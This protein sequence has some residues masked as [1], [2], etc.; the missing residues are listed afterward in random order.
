MR[1]GVD[2]PAECNP[3]FVCATE[4]RKNVR[5]CGSQDSSNVGR[6]TG[7]QY[8]FGPETGPPELVF[9]KEASEAPPQLFFSHEEKQGDYRVTIRFTNGERTRTAC[10][11]ARRGRRSGR[12]QRKILDIGCNERPEMYIDYMR[13]NYLRPEKLCCAAACQKAPTEGSDARV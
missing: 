1:V 5:I 6:W 11:P 12:R 10:T 4:R 13:M 3:L 7:I 9:P 8:R 2:V